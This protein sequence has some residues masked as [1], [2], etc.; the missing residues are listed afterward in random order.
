MRY[1]EVEVVYV[2][3]IFLLMEDEEAWE[4]EPE[5]TSDAVVALELAETELA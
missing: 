1:K 2:R 4:E 5:D 3:K